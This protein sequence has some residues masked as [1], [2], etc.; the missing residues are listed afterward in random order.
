MSTASPA[1][2]GFTLIELLVVVAIIAILVALLLPA[3][4]Q[5]REAARRTQCKNHLKQFGLAVSNYESAYGRI[6]PSTTVN[7]AATATGNNTAWGVHGRLLPF[8]EQTSLGEQVDLTRG[9]DDQQVISG[10]KVAVFACPSDPLADKARPFT[11]G[12]PTLYPTTYGFNFGTF[13]V[14]DPSTGETG[15]GLFAPNTARRMAEVTDGASNTLLASE[16]KAWQDYTR[17]GGPPTPA[18]PGS[19]AGATVIAESGDVFKGTGHTEWPDGR[20]HHT[21]FTTVMPPNTA[22]PITAPEASPDADYNSWQEGRDGASGP[23][24]RAIIT[25]RS[26]HAAQ[27][28]ALYLDGHVAPVSDAV[29]VSVWRAAGTRAGGELP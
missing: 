5:A 26:H 16:V 23:P 11:D 2:R 1:R 19:V 10:V 12:R 14:Y 6:P 22:V 28:N 18:V 7:L 3:V 27:V 17:N 9:W 25:S 29:D 4:Q 8:L 20:V 13:F 21:G 15:D 24:T